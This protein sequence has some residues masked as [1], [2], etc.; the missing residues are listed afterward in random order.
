M[1]FLYFH[2]LTFTGSNY[3]PPPSSYPSAGGPPPP[4]G[5]PYPPSRPPGPPGPPGSEQYPGYPPGNYP[6]PGWPPGGYMP[7]SNGTAAPPTTSDAY[8]GR[9]WNSVQPPVSQSGYGSPRYPPPP[10]SSQSQTPYSQTNYADQY[11][12]INVN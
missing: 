2:D 7:P 3:P 8:N 4:P 9:G 5:A 11:Q 6:R 1:F 12:V 10:P